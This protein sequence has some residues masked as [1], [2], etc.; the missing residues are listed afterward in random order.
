[1]RNVVIFIVFIAFFFAMNDT[2]AS[3]TPVVWKEGKCVVF[4]GKEYF[5]QYPS[6]YAVLS[7]W[8]GPTP[9][10]KEEKIFSMY[11]TKD[12]WLFRYPAPNAVSYRLEEPN[13]YEKIP[14]YFGGLYNS[15]APSLH[16]KYSH[17]LAD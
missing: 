5:E 13:Q 7:V 3:E 4:N 15:T 14:H 17:R 12:M 6:D 2:G 16:F 8:S 9:G 11:V 10:N 1:M